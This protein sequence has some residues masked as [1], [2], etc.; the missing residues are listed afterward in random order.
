MAGGLLWTTV[1]DSS[2]DAGS[3]SHFNELVT[4]AHLATTLGEALG[5]HARDLAPLIASSS[6]AFVSMNEMLV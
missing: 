1:E 5:K 2:A 4:T 6:M 3:A